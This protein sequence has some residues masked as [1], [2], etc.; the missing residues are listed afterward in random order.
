M[1]KQRGSL[2]IELSV[3][4]VLMLLLGVGSVSWLVQR[5]EQQRVENIAVL[6][7]RLQ[8]GVQFF[9]DTHA[10]TLAQSAVPK[11]TGVSQA[12][13]PSVLELRQL[14]FLPASFIESD[15]SFIQLYRDGVCP[16][17]RCYVHAVISHKSPFLLPNG[18]VDLEAL[19]QWQFS[20]MAK[21]LAVSAKHPDWLTGPNRKIPNTTALL[22]TV[23]PIG[24]L[25]LTASTD[26]SLFGFVR[27]ADTRNPNFK[28]D[29]SIQG[30][31]RTDADLISSGHLLFSRVESVGGRC[32]KNAAIARGV[33][34]FLIC[35]GGV[36]Q[37]FG[38]EPLPR[39][40]M[41]GFYTRSL[42]QGNCS[43][44]VGPLSN[45]INPVSNTCG[46]PAGYKAHPIVYSNN[47]MHYGGN[48]VTYACM[49]F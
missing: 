11:I 33:N 22:K 14:G 31:V 30:S 45:G 41:G 17:V 36:W 23:L 15:L 21:G 46:C 38:A 25:A 13:Q 5:A 16:G 19:R 10:N 43:V 35:Q 18:A 26:P 49:V 28:T 9:L 47:G 34:G 20:T 39:G 24:T 37:A 4:L 1:Y 3:V 7:L 2:L 6:M 27:Q 8:Q 32:T 29:V 40:S 44:G 12:F 48:M 42:S